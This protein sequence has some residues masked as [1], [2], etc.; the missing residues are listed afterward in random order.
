MKQLF[1]LATIA[2]LLVGGEPAKTRDSQKTDIKAVPSS[3]CSC[4]VCPCDTSDECGNC[5]ELSSQIESL[6]IRIH[7]YET[8]TQ[9]E[10]VVP[11]YQLYVFTADWCGPCKTLKAGIDKAGLTHD[12]E[13]AST[14]WYIDA[15][16]F[17]ETLKQYGIA[18]L[19]TSVLIDKMTGKPVRRSVGPVDV[20]A[21]F[22]ELANK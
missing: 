7:E 19:P 14:V 16:K 2:L 3:S 18:A 21:K 12:Y 17:P 11:E 4:D 10:V 5:G 15:D 20:L 6:K 22:P 1:I 9:V 8:S 13:G